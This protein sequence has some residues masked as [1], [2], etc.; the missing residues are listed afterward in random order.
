[1]RFRTVAKPHR[2]G[3]VSPWP[4][5][6]GGADGAALLGGCGWLALVAVVASGV[7]MQVSQRRATAVVRSGLAP[8]VAAIQA[9]VEPRSAEL[10]KEREAL[11]AQINEQVKHQ[12]EVLLQI[13]TAELAVREIEPQVKTL[14][15]SRGQLN[16]TLGTLQADQAAT[17]DGLEAL[18]T[19][20]AGLERTRD[21]LREEYKARYQALR[22]AFDL[23]KDDP[24]PDPM[25]RFYAEHRDSALAPAA[26]YHA[27]EKLYAGKRS[28]DALRIYKEVVRV[29]PGSA[30]GE[31]CAGRIAQIEAGGKYSE[32]AA[33]VPFA[34]YLPE[35]ALPAGAA[36]KP[37][38]TDAPPPGVP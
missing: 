12:E 28:A 9:G 34:A 37:D 3:P 5:R 27:A 32:P 14:E 31:A 10:A 23:A 15:R 13:R 30:Y 35:I 33:E 38:R 8:A 36:A 16:E 25:R 7:A 24:D 19:R 22:K 11:T 21:R 2:G 1:M 26:G 6:P 4:V 20:L 18:R 29:Y 17:G